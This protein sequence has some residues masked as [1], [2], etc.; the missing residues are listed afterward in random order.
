MMKPKQIKK[1]LRKNIAWWVH[2]T[3]LGYWHI[4]IV[5]KEKCKENPYRC[6]YCEVNWKYL[7]STVTFYIKPLK[8]QSPATIER[9]VIHELMHILLNEMRA[10][11]IDHEERVATQLQKAFS[12]VKGA[13]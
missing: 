12:W 8:S 3:G 9:V 4:G 2:W 5:F 7:V 10:K 13:K 6:G 11:G 1:L